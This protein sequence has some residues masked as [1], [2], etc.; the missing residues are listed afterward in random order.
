M[1]D[2]SPTVPPLYWWVESDTG[3]P[4]TMN[5]GE[6]SYYSVFSSEINAEAFRRGQQMLGDLKLNGSDKTDHLIEMVRAARDS[7]G[8]DDFL[9]N[10]RPTTAGGPNRGPRRR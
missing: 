9:L 3:T 7:L 2:E 8:C 4:I 10:P 5:V 6:T 1:A